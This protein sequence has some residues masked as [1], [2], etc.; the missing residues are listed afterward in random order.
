[1]VFC[2]VFHLHSVNVAFRV[3]AFSLFES[4]P[5]WHLVWPH[6]S[7]EIDLMGADIDR[8]CELNKQT[9]RYVAHDDF[10]A[11][12]K[13]FELECVDR[14]Q[15]AHTMKRCPQCAKEVP[16]KFGRYWNCDTV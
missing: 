14:H 8:A 15:L 1:M 7:Y 16:C 12:A 5:T 13:S 9:V 11:I 6:C 10:T 4:Q 3:F 2:V